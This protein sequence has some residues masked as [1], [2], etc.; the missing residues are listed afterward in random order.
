MT[1]EVLARSAAHSAPSEMRLRGRRWPETLHR[2]VHQEPL[3]TWPT[4][5]CWADARIL[6]HAQDVPELDV[7]PLFEPAGGLG[8]LRHRAGRDAAAAGR[9]APAMAAGRV[10]AMEVMLG[11]SDS[12]KDAGPVTAHARPGIPRR[13]DIAR[14]GRRSGGIDVRAHATVDGG[15]G[16]AAGGGPA[17]RAVLAAARRGR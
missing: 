3:G 16:G 12:S 14:W 10:D 15:C 9:A 4:S 6:A 8:E 1:R 11:Y 2:V 13:C 7:I 17:N 5:T